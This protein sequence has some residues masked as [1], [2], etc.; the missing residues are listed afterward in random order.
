L[1][2]SFIAN[3][4]IIEEN[5]E[6]LAHHFSDSHSGLKWDLVFTLPAWL[7]NWW[8]NFGAGSEL[9]LR[10]VWQ[11]ERLIGLAPLQIKNAQTSFVG[12]IN[13]CD[14]LDFVTVPGSERDFLNA[15]LEDLKGKG[16]RELVLETVRPDS[17]VV[18]YLLPLALEKQY[19]VDYKKVD[20]SL[21]L[22]LP[23]NWEGYLNLLDGKQRHELKRKMRNLQGSGEVAYRVI[24][25]KQALLDSTG[26]FLQLFPEYRQDKAQFLTAEMQTYFRSL[27]TA[28][29]TTGILKYG[30]LEIERKIVAMIMYFDYN[31]SVFLY[32]SAYVPEY[33]PLS[34]GII[35]K[36]NC[37]EDCIARRKK[38]FDFLKGNEPYKYNLAGKEIPLY[39]CKINI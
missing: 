12:S 35:S 27:A 8:Q 26:I 5:F 2:L 22:E 7:Q 16:I 36:A 20:V 3:L 38:R 25:E 39:S 32:N 29:A 34:V 13:V 17:A 6:T 19:K 23:G 28:L 37:I 14:Y 24:E 30:Q 21:D 1:R 33:K 9:Y 31:D 4:R 10:S 11:D 18:T 15:V